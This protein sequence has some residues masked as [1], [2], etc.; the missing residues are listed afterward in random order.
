MFPD[1]FENDQ[2]IEHQ[3]RQPSLFSDALSKFIAI[4]DEIKEDKKMLKEKESDEPMEL[5]DLRI[6]QRELNK[7]IKDRKKEHLKELIEN[8]TEYNDIRQR[9]QAGKEELENTKSHLFSVAAKQTDD[10]GDLNESIETT[11]GPVRLQTQKEVGV[12]INGK[13]LK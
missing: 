4:Q 10:S 5:E 3:V 9:I 2:V 11:H 13:R 6:Q 12:Y 1:Q 8:D 7:Q